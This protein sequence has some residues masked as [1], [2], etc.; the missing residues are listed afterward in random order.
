MH[1]FP[2]ARA[3]QVRR[4]P[5]RAAARLAWWTGW[6]LLALVSMA[7]IYGALVYSGR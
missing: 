4:R 3:P 2:R 6:V 7:V 1:Q 5:G